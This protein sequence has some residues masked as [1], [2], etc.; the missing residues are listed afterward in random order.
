[1]LVLR[2]LEACFAPSLTDSM[3]AAMTMMKILVDHGDDKSDTV[4]DD[5]SNH[6]IRDD[7]NTNDVAI[8]GHGDN[9]DINIDDND[10]DC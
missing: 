9:D 7:S 10:G 2:L 6:N 3:E 8:H 1:M 4:R 5:S